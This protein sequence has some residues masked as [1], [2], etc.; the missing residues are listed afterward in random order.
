MIAGIVGPLD[1]SRVASFMQ[2]YP[3][4]GSAM[5]LALALALATAG[6]AGCASPVPVSPGPPTP[7]SSP[8]AFAPS[9]SPSPSEGGVPFEVRMAG[10]IGCAQFPYGC[11]ARLS[12]L[13]PDARLT[14]TWRPPE[15]DPEWIPELT[16]SV[17][18]TDHLQL[19]P[20]GSPPVLAPGRH[21]VV[22]SLLGSYDTPSLNP[23]GSV[24]T[25][26]LA[27]CTATVEVASGSGPLAAVVTFVPDGSSFGGTCSIKI[28]EP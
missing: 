9:P 25:D 19:Q 22:V 20:V 18:T 17:D 5:R 14:S 28:E 15:T 11:F 8:A 2:G 7:T 1:A 26:L 3:I 21:L 12:V 16:D 4:K 6:L 10:K 27:R 23:D 24:A 13:G